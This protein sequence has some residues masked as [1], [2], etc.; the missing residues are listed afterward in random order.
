[1][2]TKISGRSSDTAK[3]NISLKKSLL[4]KI[5]AYADYLGLSRS[6]FMC[7]C[8]SQYINAH[9]GMSKIKDLVEIMKEFKERDNL[10]EE[11][12]KKIDEMDSFV[13]MLEEGLI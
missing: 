4:E 5:D 6:A 2:D 9:E 13:S 10:S 12:L 11:D 7:Y 3:I 8:C 1:M